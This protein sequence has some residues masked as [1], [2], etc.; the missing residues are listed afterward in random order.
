MF[1][2]G[3]AVPSST[4]AY[5]PELCDKAVIAKVLSSF[6]FTLTTL[7]VVVCTDEVSKIKGAC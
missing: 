4:K 2:V 7:H 6:S 5:F 3:N 1:L